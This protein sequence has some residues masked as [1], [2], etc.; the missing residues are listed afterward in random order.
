MTLRVQAAVHLSRL[1]LDQ[2]QYLRSRIADLC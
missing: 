1:S 2:V